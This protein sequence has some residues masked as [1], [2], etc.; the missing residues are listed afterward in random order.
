MATQTV[1]RGLLA[2]I[3]IATC[4][5][6]LAPPQLAQQPTRPATFTNGQEEMQAGG[7]LL[8][9]DPRVQQRSYTLKDTNETMPYALFVSSKVT[10]AAKSPLIVALH[11]R[12]GNQSALMLEHLRL[13]ELA[14]QGGYI[15]AA[16]MGYSPD[17]NYGVPIVPGRG[18]PVNGPARD[19]VFADSGGTAVTDRARKRELSEQ[20]V[21]NVLALVKAEFN[22]DERRTYLIGHSM[23]G[24][25]ALYLGVKHAAT[26]A[27][28]AAIAPSVQR[29]PS[30]D[31][32]STVKTMPII[33]VHGDADPS[34]PVASTRVWVDKLKELG[35]M[36]EYHE[37]AG[38]DHGSAIPAGMPAIFTF[39][40]THSK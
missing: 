35:M 10:K 37:I 24:Q 18:G 20:D 2:G 15:V 26:W 38:A 9:V 6:W 32:L 29:S 4:Q 25:G 30:P 31:I 1:T 33:L 36:Y 39:F 21:L 19:P 11:G 12:G 28:I 34:V 17:G 3:T 23:G 40:S 16:P 8:R 14:E 5:L 27:A 22:V 13:V 7:R